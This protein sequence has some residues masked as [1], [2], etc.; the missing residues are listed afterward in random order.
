MQAVISG[1][2]I[3]GV[4]ACTFYLA[5]ALTQYI[6]LKHKVASQQKIVKLTAALAIILHGAFSYQE[7][8]T[9]AGINIGFFPM[10]SLTSLAITS[11]VMLS[12]LRRPVENLLIVLLPF[13][14]FTVF[15]SL[16]QDGSYKPRSDIGSGIFFHIALSVIAYGLLTTA[17]LQ[18][19]LLSIGD[20]E[21]KHRKLAVLR[22]MPP[23]QTMESLL[24][25][26]ITAGLCFLSLSIISGFIFLNNMALPG[27]IHHTSI[28]LAAW[29]VFS[30]LIWG[31]LK[32]GWRG[33]L[34]SRWTLAGFGLL[35]LGYF[36]SKLVL[37]LFLHR[38]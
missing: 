35:L 3:Y 25:E 12:S 32:L 28:T 21:L 11:V 23:L 2:S 38:T 26:L 1:T 19:A 36:G 15:L 20:Y 31:R 17:A 33:S 18:A 24:F 27:L 4:L 29:M 5:S 14:T 9:A 6:G 13:A 7:I 22:S 30:I 8:Y 37:E 16:W 34:A 10:I